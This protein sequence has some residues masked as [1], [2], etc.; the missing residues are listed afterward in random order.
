M[1]ALPFQKLVENSFL[2]VAMSL[3]TSVAVFCT[4]FASYRIEFTAEKLVELLKKNDS[5][6]S[7]NKVEL[8]PSPMTLIS[9]KG[10]MNRL[11]EV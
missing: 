2:F 7:E 9:A 5:K 6:A 4:G 11:F 3:I 1:L 10:P 8:P